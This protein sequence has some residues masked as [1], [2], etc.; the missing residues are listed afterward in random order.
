MLTVEVQNFHSKLLENKLISKLLCDL[1][2]V[3]ELMSLNKISEH[4]E[5]SLNQT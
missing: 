2:S 5:S 3:S 1:L 4:N